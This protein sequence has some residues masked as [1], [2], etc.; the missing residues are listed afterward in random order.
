MS[1]PAADRSASRSR[2][3][4]GNE[5]YYDVHTI[6]RRH[7]RESSGRLRVASEGLRP[8]HQEIADTAKAKIDQRLAQLPANFPAAV[9][10]SI[11][12]GA[13]RRIDTLVTA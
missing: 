5:A 3:L 1:G 7:F 8:D 9:E 12:E 11:G 4:G 6:L 13:K 10:Q 2:P